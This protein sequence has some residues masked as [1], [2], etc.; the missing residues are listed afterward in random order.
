MKYC[1]RVKKIDPRL[2]LLLLLMHAITNGIAQRT[3]HI[4]VISID[5]LR[6][7]FY[8]DKKWPTPNMQALKNVGV[9][10]LQM[11][12]VFPSFTYPAH[13]AMMTG[14]LP[15][16]SGIYY[17][18]PFEP[19]GI[20]GN[21][22]WKSSSIKVPTL[23]MELRRAGL[24]SAAVQWPVSV[25]AEIDYN[26][27]E[28]WSPA[29]PGD[30]ITESRKYATKGLVEE[31]EAYATGKLTSQNMNERY[32][33]LDENAARIAAYIFSKY[34]PNLLALHFASVDGA[35]HEHGT[36]S[37]S[38]ILAVA[39]VDRAIGHVLETVKK[40]DM[41]DSTAILI[42][43][44]HGF[45][46]ISTVVRPNVWLSQH[47]LQ[48]NGVN[49]RAKFQPAGGSAFL[50]LKDNK[51]Q[52]AFEKIQQILKGL[53]AEYHK[54]FQVVN[55][56]GLDSLGADS[57]ALLALSARPGIVFGSASQG[58]VIDKTTGGH[59]GYNPNF[60]EMMTGFIGWGP[61]LVSRGQVSTL[62]ICDVADIIAQLLNIYFP[63]PD[64]SLKPGILLMDR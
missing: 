7:E 39:A 13:V 43:G 42:V 58:A 12:S 63:T 9:F 30:R 40:S 18:A 61:G 27:P 24:K 56:R 8:L 54:Y 37:D 17:N 32:L 38:I 60:P 19:N 16:R 44:D 1:F 26:I 21:W 62:E 22:N 14:A 11:K 51:D 4:I 59:H 10:A 5:G 6:P 57:S 64:G 49:W 36:C 25:G 46:D 2:L 3:R 31:V 45:S 52:Q 50:Y 33:S 29:D 53:P 23:W 20:S 15:A 35:Q 34:K 48:Q 28:I 41:A 55:R 47:G